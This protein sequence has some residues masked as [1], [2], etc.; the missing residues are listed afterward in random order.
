MRRWLYGVIALVVLLGI[1]CI[2]RIH[3]KE[4][5]SKSLPVNTNLPVKTLTAGNTPVVVEVATTPAE[6]ELGLSNR[7]S[8]KDG[9]GMLF[10]FDPPKQV[11]FW[12]KD[13]RFSLDMVF[14]DSNGI[15]LNIAHN[16][17]PASYPNVFPSAGP[18]MY[19]LE[20]PAGYTTREGIAVGQ[21]IVVQ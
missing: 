6:R 7:D 4:E 12:M 1:V 13:M 16:A 10:V 21:K 17:E 15:I 20:V 3:Y 9:T 5:Q 8:L 18:A 14:A 19:V 2:G 11:G